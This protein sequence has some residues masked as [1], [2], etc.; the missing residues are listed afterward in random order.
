MILRLDFSEILNIYSIF[1]E[2][3]ETFQRKFKI[4]M[5]S[6]KLDAALNDFQEN[7]SLWRSLKVYKG[8]FIKYGTG[9]AEGI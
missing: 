9:G 3:K 6:K 5:I 8:A 1:E 4:I 7:H 2:F